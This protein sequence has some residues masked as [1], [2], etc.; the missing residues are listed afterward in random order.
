M[1]DLISKSKIRQRIIL[2]FINNKGKEYY[3][4]QIAKIVGTSA[5]TTQRELNRLLKSSLITYE[6][7]GNLSLFKLNEKNPLLKEIESIVNKTIGLEIILKNEVKKLRGIEY[8]FIF[9]SYA[10]GNFKAESDIDVYI[11]GDINSDE[12]HAMIRHA[13]KLTQK[14]INPHISSLSEFTKKLRRLYFI[15]DI[16][17]KYSL[18]AGDKDEFAKIIKRAR[19]AG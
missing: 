12:A 18:I 17:I 15:K 1:L 16:I 8:A 11:I 19:N 6:R 9:G 2:L 5:G 7:K 3:I 10:K 13:E 4:N 14:E